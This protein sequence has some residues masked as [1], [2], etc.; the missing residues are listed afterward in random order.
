MAQDCRSSPAQD[1]Q[2]SVTPCL[3]SPESAA[4]IG[5][6]SSGCVLLGLGLAVCVPPLTTTVMSALGAKQPG[7][8][9][10][11]NNAVSRVAGLL[12][13]ALLGIV[14][15]QAFNGE[16]DR[17]LTPIEIA[18]EARKAIDAQRDRLAGIEFPKT[19][20]RRSARRSAKP[21]ISPLSL[22]F[23]WS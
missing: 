23:A 18:P 10:G 1:S 9:S 22:A 14:I 15:L 19:C 11:V 3:L 13:I 20:M 4:V 8:A 21:S 12:G 6:R 17:R 5:Q 7:V 2:L 16:L